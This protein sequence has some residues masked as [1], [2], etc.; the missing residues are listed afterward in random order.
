MSAPT[1]E[2]IPALLDA[3]NAMAQRWLA[4]LGAHP[5]VAKP[6]GPPALPREGIGATAALALLRE[7]IEPHLAAMP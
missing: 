7:R 6:A 5:V 2:E 4:G 3:A 1:T